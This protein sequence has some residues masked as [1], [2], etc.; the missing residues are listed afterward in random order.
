MAE[1]PLKKRSG[2]VG[3]EVPT[4]MRLPEPAEQSSQRNHQCDVRNREIPERELLPVAP[5]TPLDFALDDI[6]DVLHDISCVNGLIAIKKE[7]VGQGPKSPPHKSSI[8]IP[9]R[10]N[11]NERKLLLVLAH[12]HRR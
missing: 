4:P 11:R 6:N 8:R 5:V 12:R 7:S 3:T 1:L 2:G 10:H 9:L